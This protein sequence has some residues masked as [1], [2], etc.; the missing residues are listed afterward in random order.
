MAFVSQHGVDDLRVSAFEK[1]RARRNVGAIV[2]VTRDDPLARRLD[3]VDEGHGRGVGKVQQRRFGFER[4]AGGGVF[5][6]ADGDLLEIF[7]APQIAI[8]ANSTQVEACNAKG[9]RARPR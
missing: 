4:K 8:L 2:I 6:V 5:G 3:A 9:F 7:D 1:P